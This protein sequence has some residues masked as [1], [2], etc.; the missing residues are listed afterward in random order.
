M[1]NEHIERI[2]ITGGNGYIGERLA[3]LALQEGRHV[4][5]LGR[6][7]PQGL[8]QANFVLWQLGDPVPDAACLAQQ[9]TA[10]IH[11]AHDWQNTLGSQGEEGH[12][13][14]TGTQMLLDSA[15]GLGINRFV[16]VSS[17]SA[18]QDS[19]NIYGRVKWL[20]EQKIVGADT[21]SVRVGLVYGGAKKGMFGL[22]CTLVK[23]L[24]IIP[25]ICPQQ[26]T[27]PI[28]LD[29]VC[30]GLLRLAD[31]DL[32]GVKGLA[33]AN[34]VAFGDVLRTLGRE[35]YGR[36]IVI[37]P[38]PLSLALWGARLTSYIPCIPTVDKERILG[39][40][41]TRF[42]STAAD[43][44]AI[45]LVVLPL[46]VGLRRS[47]WGRKALLA[48]GKLLLRY[49]LGAAP[50][51]TLQKLYARAV[52]VSVPDGGAL[53]LF[54]LYTVF[55]ACLRLID[56]IGDKRPLAQRMRLATELVDAS[57]EGME[58]L[59]EPSRGRRMM[60]LMVAL[61]VDVVAF[62]VRLFVGVLPHD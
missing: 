13:N 30:R 27:Q 11:L 52:R 33:G 58:L 1:S 4:V 2:I 18:R 6:K 34:P 8:D 60:T 19:M 5:L 40:A 17:Q 47:L 26:Q 46:A 50:S 9:D 54:P 24:P 14:V 10:I 16:F 12:L 41:G 28:H 45:G 15:R 43:L 39:L 3:E 55:P 22:L 36:R 44:E 21:V 62:P 35:A 56:P 7:K 31:G 49:V 61:A 59:H 23:K 38:V 37:I 42:T 57:A 25:M 32:T 48:E 20:I 53:G 29:E 51:L